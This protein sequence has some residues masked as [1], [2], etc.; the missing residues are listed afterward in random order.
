MSTP[1][2]WTPEGL[3]AHDFG[4]PE[5]FVDEMLAPQATTLLYG[6]REA[7]KTQLMLTLV[8][9]MQEESMFLGRFQARRARVA[10]CEFDMPETAFQKRMQKAVE[11]F[12]FD[13]ALFRVMTGNG[14]T[15]D[16]FAATKDS[17]WVKL[18]NE[19]KPDL[20]MFDSTRKTHNKSEIDTSVPSALYTKWRD[21]FPGAGFAATHHVSKAP[22]KFEQRKRGNSAYRAH[23][24]TESFRGTTAW[25]DD[26]DYG[27]MLSSVA[28]KEKGRRIVQLT[29]G[30]TLAEETKAQ[31]IPVRLDTE[32]GLFLVPSEPT[33]VER[34]KQ[35]RLQHPTHSKAD[36]I[37]W[38]AAEERSRNKATYYRWALD[39]GYPKG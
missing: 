6:A 16:N 2:I 20:I 23:E 8:R 33:P 27:V 28:G 1:R 25:L 24:E 30:R 3:V 26:A 5:Y 38:I 14:G 29:R 32:F 12:P 7:G 9:A 10:L 15:V 18:V 36:A 39:A 31:L 22:S 4:C 17:K 34:L 37:E 13:P 11:A 35:Y 21:L 19:F